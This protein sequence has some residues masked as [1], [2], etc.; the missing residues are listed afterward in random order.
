MGR[1]I[2]RLL[3]NKQAVLLRFARRRNT[4]KYGFCRPA[5]LRT[6]STSVLYSLAGVKKSSCASK[7]ETNVLF[8]PCHFV[9]SFREE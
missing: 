1:A 3:P 2:R 4:A 9:S 6:L 5:G 7:A 8:C